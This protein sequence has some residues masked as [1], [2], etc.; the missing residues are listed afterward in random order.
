M[1]CAQEQDPGGPTSPTPRHDET[2]TVASAHIAELEPKAAAERLER[3]RKAPEEDL[4]DLE[5]RV[6]ALLETIMTENPGPMRRAARIE[7]NS[8]GNAAI[9][10]L[11]VP[12]DTYEIDGVL[13]D[14]RKQMAA[15]EALSD[16]GTYESVEAML[17]RVEQQAA[18]GDP[19]EKQWAR[20]QCAWRIGFTNH[21]WTVPRLLVCLENEPHH[22]VL[23]WIARTLSKFDNL[24]GVETCRWLK[25]NARF[26]G[27]QRE[28]FERLTEMQQDFGLQVTSDLVRVWRGEKPEGMPE[29]ELHPSYNLQLEVW[30]RIDDLAD[31]QLRGVDEARDA[32]ANM[33]GWVAEP[34]GL[35]LEDASP[36]V[37][38]HAA[39]CL[40]RMGPRGRA[41]G[42]ALLSLLGREPQQAAQAAAA[43]GAI[44]YGPAAE[45]LARRLGPETDFELRVAS[46]RA[47]GVLGSSE[48]SARFLPLFAESE[49]IDLRAAAAEAL[50]R[51][52]PTLE[53]EAQVDF[54]LAQLSEA[55]IDPVGP[56]D[57]LGV[58]ILRRGREGNPAAQTLWRK[59]VELDRLQLA[60]GEPL[61]EAIR[62][63]RRRKILNEALPAIRDAST[64]I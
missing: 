16:I 18:P 20:Q 41:A 14:G 59:W 36:Y 6:N 56:E 33:N 46:T 37:R 30:R 13:V 29:R 26:P 27:V 28:A 50:V 45:A 11:C 25:S 34:L 44:E 51:T 22:E 40:E 21:D 49:P 24:A 12:L 32:L 64:D 7:L 55:Q 39:Q 53:V 52:A 8:F 4:T 15:A 3:A 10:Y 2:T 1:A 31:W 62:L 42:P 43:L 60:P 57:A 48:S 5:E 23:L 61:K 17:E 47:L 9:P 58:W 38:L 54:L 35:A 19:N 63:A